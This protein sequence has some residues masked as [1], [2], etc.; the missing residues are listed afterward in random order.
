MRFTPIVLAALIGAPLAAAADSPPAPAKTEKKAA[1]PPAG[2]KNA[3]VYTNEDLKDAKESGGKGGGGAVTFLEDPAGGHGT[4]T[5]SSSSEGGSSGESRNAGSEEGRPGEAGWRQRAHEYRDLLGAA[6][7]EVER[8]EAKLQALSNP[9]RQPQPIEALQPDPNHL[10]T[11]SEERQQLEKDLEVARNA[12]ADA[13]K[14]SADFQED[15]RR[16]GIPAGW[17]E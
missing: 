16:Q 5:S 11:T 17:L 8:L 9:M 1:K 7:A 13:E 14:A 2:D 4:D 10:L 15:A 6:R 3:K 12:L